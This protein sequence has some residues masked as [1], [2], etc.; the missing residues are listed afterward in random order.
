[1]TGSP[2]NV[3][4]YVPCKELREFAIVCARFSTKAFVHPTIGNVVQLPMRVTWPLVVTCDH[5]G[6]V[7]A[8]AR[9]QQLLP[10][11]QVE[12]SLPGCRAYQSER[13]KTLMGPIACDSLK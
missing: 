9:A 2:K 11:S 5:A 6:F 4:Q 7:H 12:A 8:G 3:D 1:M 10:P 13:G